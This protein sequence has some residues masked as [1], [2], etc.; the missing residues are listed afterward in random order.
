MGW[1]WLCYTKNREI[2]GKFSTDPRFLSTFRPEKEAAAKLPFCNGP[3]RRALIVCQ[4]HLA[5]TAED[6]LCVLFTALQ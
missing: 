1:G 3:I 4:N 5:P 2:C 6:A